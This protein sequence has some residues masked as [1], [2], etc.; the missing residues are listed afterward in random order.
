MRPLG[1]APDGQTPVLPGRASHIVSPRV[2]ETANC[3]PMPEGCSSWHSVQLNMPMGLIWPRRYKR[4]VGRLVP[5]KLYK[6]GG[7]EGSLA[8]RFLLAASRESECDGWSC[9]SHF[10]S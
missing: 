6:K 1:T 4:N 2:A 3:Q 9:S 10:D 7:C 8:L 5:T